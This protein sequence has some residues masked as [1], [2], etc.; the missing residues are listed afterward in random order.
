MKNFILG[1]DAYQLTSFPIAITQFKIFQQ[2]TL[3][4]FLVCSMEVYYDKSPEKTH[5]IDSK[6]AE[7]G[8]GDTN[9]YKFDR[10]M[11]RHWDAWDTYSKRNHLFIA[12]LSINK[13]YL[14]ECN[15]KIAHD[16][17]FGMESDCPCKPFGGIIIQYITFSIEK[18]TLPF[19]SLYLGRLF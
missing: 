11:V 8:G 9:V 5:E 14:L 16:L 3:Q 7:A 13:D 10:L 6:K 1:G 19:I 2:P 18:K 4:I 17:M 12:P 15:S